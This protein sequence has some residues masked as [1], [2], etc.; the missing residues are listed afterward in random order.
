[1]MMAG[2]FALVAIVMGLTLAN[3]PHAALGLF[4]ATLILALL[5]FRYHATDTLA[6]SL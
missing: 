4:V 1:M 5:T 2:L 3:R 6:I